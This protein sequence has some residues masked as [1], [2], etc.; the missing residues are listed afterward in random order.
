MGVAALDPSYAV[1]GYAR[2]HDMCGCVCVTGMGESM[3]ASRRLLP[4]LSLTAMAFGVSTVCAQNYP[5]K[6]IR[7]IASETAGVGDF[8]GRLIAQGISAPLGQSVIVENRGVLS[9]G[10]VAE[11]PPDGH[12]LLIHGSSLWI[13]P[14]LRSNVPY[15][16]V[17][18]FASVAMAA[19]APN[20]LVVTS[21]L[22]VKTVKQ[23]IALAKSRPGELNYASGQ[24]G[25]SNHLAA[26]LFK[27][28]AGVNIV[29]IPYR[30]LGQSLT[31]LIAGEVQVMF[32]NAASAMPNVKTGKLR[33]LAVTSAEPSALA[34]GMPTVAESGLPGYESG[35]IVGLF[36]PARTPR[37]VIDRLNDE[38]VRLLARPDIKEKFF[39]VGSE[40]AG[41][42]PEILAAAVKSEM[43]RLGKM[44]KTAGIREE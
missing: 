9:G 10:L 2:W 14:L 11:A 32:P 34:P 16:P 19:R 39:N 25:A 13:A 42:P 36:A 20:L 1:T 40:A 4:M 22:P 38:V 27:V 37:P 28:M 21:A 8:A 5:L 18:D 15:D 7:M 12:T 43:A 30:G 26:E 3:R 24:S 31:N 44:I 23:L 29:R 33:A 35:S 41:G 6:V 17:R